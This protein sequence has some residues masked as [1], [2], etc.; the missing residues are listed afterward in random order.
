MQHQFEKWM[1]FYGKSFGEYELLKG[2]FLHKQFEDKINQSTY[3]PLVTHRNIFLCVLLNL[4]S[5]RYL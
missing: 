1:G 5:H 2:D 4:V 3:V